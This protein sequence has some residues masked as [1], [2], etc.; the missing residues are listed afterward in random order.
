MKRFRRGPTRSNGSPRWPWIELVFIRPPLFP[1]IKKCYYI[2]FY[3]H[4]V[5]LYKKAGIPRTFW[6]GLL[7][8]AQ[9]KTTVWL[10]GM[11]RVGKTAFCQTLWDAEFFEWE[12]PRES[13]LGHPQTWGFQEGGECSTRMGLAPA[14]FNAEMLYS[15]FPAL[16]SQQPD[17]QRDSHLLPG[18][19]P[20]FSFSK[21][22]R[23]SWLSTFPPVPAWRASS[24]VSKTRRV[25]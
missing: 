22:T 20:R 4:L 25:V 2:I 13:C 16:R 14:S 11:R 6:A 8:P 3:L 15:T 7:S 10:T 5:S 18:I 19:P 12:S 9:E 17:Q 1:P 23:K 24:G 21:A